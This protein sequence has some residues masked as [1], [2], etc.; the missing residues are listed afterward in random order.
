MGDGAATRS[1]ELGPLQPCAT[2]GDGAPVVMGGFRSRCRGGVLFS[3]APS[4]V[5]QEQL[6]AGLLRPD[7]VDAPGLAEACQVFAEIQDAPDVAEG[8]APVGLIFDYDA[9]FAW[10][11]QP[12]GAGLS[13]FGLILDTYRAMRGLGL[14]VDI[15]PPDFADFSGYKVIAAPG[16]MHMSGALKSALTAADAQVLIGPRSGARNVE[17]AIP[18]PL[19]PGIAGLDVTVTHIES[20]RPDMP[21][22]LEGGG[23]LHHY[24]EALEGRAEVTERTLDGAAVVMS[25]GNLNYVGAWMDATALRRVIGA[26]CARTG[27][28]TMDLPDGV[29]LR[30]CGT[31]RFWFNHTTQAVQINGFTL[32]PCG[33]RREFLTGKP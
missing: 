9:D 31:E 16:L 15:L 33:V 32:P 26:A 20:L 3:L 11:T 7:S 24:R 22:K 4:P 30:D 6:H 17:M 18:L 10:A 27:V 23:H 2:A 19:P 14:S 13:Y 12:H 25:S 1:G 5:A 8:C 29:R 21:V 28:S